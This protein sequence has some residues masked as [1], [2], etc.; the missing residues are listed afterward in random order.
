MLS[1]DKQ[2]RKRLQDEIDH[3]SGELIA[4]EKK[5]ATLHAKRRRIEPDSKIPPCF[6]TPNGEPVYACSNVPF[7]RNVKLN[8][9]ER[10]EWEAD[11]DYDQELEN[12]DVCGDGCY[13]M[14]SFLNHTN[15]SLRIFPHK[16]AVTTYRNDD[17]ALHFTF[18]DLK[19]K[20]DFEKGVYIPW[21]L[22]WM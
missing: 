21:P 14:R 12:I 1:G 6:D 8:T 19:K 20:Y 9:L 3:V 4:L 10:G 22:A 13:L 5:V 15:H 16:L 7:P 2:Y 11:F 17:H 18:S